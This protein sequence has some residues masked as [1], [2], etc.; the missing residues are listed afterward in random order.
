MNKTGRR[1]KGELT[2]RFSSALF[3]V[4]S[5]LD[6]IIILHILIQSAL[7][8]WEQLLKSA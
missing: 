3:G 6:H 8:M 2:P 1:L 7:K 4:V 5:C